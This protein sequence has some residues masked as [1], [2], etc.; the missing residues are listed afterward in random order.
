MCKDNGFID[1]AKTAFRFP[2][3]SVHEIGKERGL[4]NGLM[5][6]GTFFI[7][8]QS[9]SKIFALN[10]MML[11]LKEASRRKLKGNEPELRKPC[12]LR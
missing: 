6:L 8:I 4:V 2:I 12:K 9:N 5:E 3:S 10:R 7:K 11:F 1:I